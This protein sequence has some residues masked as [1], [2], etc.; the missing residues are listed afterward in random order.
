M[1]VSGSSAILRAAV[2]PFKNDFLGAGLD[3]RRVQ[4]IAQPDAGPL[5]VADRAGAPLDAGGFFAEKGAAVAGA[6]HGGEHTV[7][8]HRDEL[9]ER[10]PRRFRD[11]A[12]EGQR[13][14]LRIANRRRLEVVAHEKQ[15]VRRHPACDLLERRLAVLGPAGDD[16]AF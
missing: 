13:P 8:R 1:I 15:P 9:R 14:G 10:P 2:C 16:L 7:L 4:Q 11:Q 6:F 12:L 3:A 5:G